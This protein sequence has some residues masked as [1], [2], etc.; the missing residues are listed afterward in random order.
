MS[1][2][3]TRARKPDRPLEAGTVLEA[4]ARVFRERGFGAAGMG[5]VARALGVSRP[6]LYYYFPSKDAI[7]ASLVETVTVSIAQQA[8]SLTESRRDRD[9][10]VRLRELAARHAG[11]I[12]A[13]ASI[14]HVLQQS[15]P[16]LPERLRE[17]NAQGKAVIF[18]SFERVIAAGVRQ[19]VFRTVRPSVAALAVLG[20]CNG[21]ASWF[22]PDG[23]LSAEAVGE[24]IAEMAVASLALPDAGPP[25]AELAEPLAQARAAL[26]R[27]S[28]LIEPA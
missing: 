5:D 4:A 15:Q 1:K 27:L 20:M 25:R 13:H 23:P 16:Y 10:R 21:C 18:R 22:R 28:E 19:G 7:L 8:R 24:Q 26:G 17:V 14:F 12:A 2:T 6:A 11:F 3:V 9:P